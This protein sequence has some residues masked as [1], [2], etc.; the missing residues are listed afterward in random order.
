[1]GLSKAP[2]SLED[3][4]LRGLKGLVQW[5]PALHHGSHC[6][7]GGSALSGALQLS[8]LSPTHGQPQGGRGPGPSLQA[9]EPR[10]AP[11]YPHPWLPHS[12]PLPLRL[13][14][15]SR[16]G[17]S[18]QGLW[19]PE[20]YAL[21]MG[22]WPCQSAGEGSLPQSAGLFWEP[23]EAVAQASLWTSIWVRLGEARVPGLSHCPV[24]EQSMVGH[25]SERMLPVCGTST[26]HGAHPGC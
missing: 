13:V 4:I 14:L 24:S 16:A 8:T 11:P 26:A 23:R 5:V 12:W 18:G 3:H 15:E 25:F 17:L 2:S 20:F 19:R 6:P 7:S 21:F 1:M 10:A 22:L 9:R